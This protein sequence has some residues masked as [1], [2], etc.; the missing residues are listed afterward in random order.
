MNKNSDLASRDQTQFKNI[1]KK[2]LEELRSLNPS[3]KMHMAYDVIAKSHGYESWNIMSGLIKN[4]KIGFPTENANTS[5][6][7]ETNLVSIKYENISKL[8]KNKIIPYYFRE[9]IFKFFDQI[10]EDN[11]EEHNIQWHYRAVDMFIKVMNVFFWFREKDKKPVKWNDIQNAMNFDYIMEIAQKDESYGEQKNK[12]P[13]NL[14]ED[15]VYYIKNLPGAD[16]TEHQKMHAYHQQIITG[17]LNKYYTFIKADIERNNI[18]ENFA[19]RYE[20]FI[21]KDTKNKNYKEDVSDIF[22]NQ[23]IQLLKNHLIFLMFK[24]NNKVSIEEII[25]SLNFEWY[26]NE[27]SSLEYH[28]RVKMFMH[29]I[30]TRDELLFKNYDKSKHVYEHISY[31]V[32]SNLE[33]IFKNKNMANCFVK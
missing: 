12:I 15:I 22:K 10:I 21:F 14:K 25:K 6:N 33:E 8:D 9:D 28:K 13:D 7:K 31:I 3:A 24:N 29:N 18:I 26:K 27:L 5:Y 30:I 20:K 1:A 19:K 16:E 17:Y 32:K 23:S 4:G 11:K 2:I